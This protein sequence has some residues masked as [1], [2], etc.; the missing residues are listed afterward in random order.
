MVR[1]DDVAN[2]HHHHHHHDSGLEKIMIFLILK[3]QIFFI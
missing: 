1:L 3:N 2:D